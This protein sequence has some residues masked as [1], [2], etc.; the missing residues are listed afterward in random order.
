MSWAL[1]NGSDDVNL[2]K[3]VIYYQMAKIFK[4][5]PQQVDEIEYETV[6]GMLSMEASVRKKESAEIK[7]NGKR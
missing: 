2:Q 5:T 6:L 4:Y 7:K 3:E 1:N